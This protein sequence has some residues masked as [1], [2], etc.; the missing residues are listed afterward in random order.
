MRRRR[1]EKRNFDLTSA[2]VT[3]ILPFNSEFTKVELCILHHIHNVNISHTG[4]DIKKV[5]SVY[6]TEKYPGLK[7]AIP[8]PYVKSKNTQSSC[9]KVHLLSSL[10]TGKG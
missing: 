7:E 10:Q 5:N 1:R 3:S 8:L 2:Q 6:C 4:D 9:H